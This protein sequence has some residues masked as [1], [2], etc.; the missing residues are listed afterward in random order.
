MKLRADVSDIRQQ[1]GKTALLH[2]LVPH[3][4]AL[5][6]WAAVQLWATKLDTAVYADHLA[7]EEMQATVDS[8]RVERQA[9]QIAQLRCAA[10][11][12]TCR[13]GTHGH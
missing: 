13:G 9:H 6:T 10:K 8:I 5:M 11:P 2:A 1:I 7:K 4:L 12:A 3:L